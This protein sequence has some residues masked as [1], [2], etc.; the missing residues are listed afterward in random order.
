MK[1]F[2]IAEKWDEKK[3]IIVKFIAGEFTEYMMA[4][5]FKDAYNQ[6]YYT[7]AKIVEESELLNK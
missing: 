2:V 5:L 1:Y 7:D 3:G 6:N 4:K